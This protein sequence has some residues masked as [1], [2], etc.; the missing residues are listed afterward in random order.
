MSQS[1]KIF[2]E[3]KV[4]SGLDGM[5]GSIGAVPMAA[6][7]TGSPGGLNPS[8]VEVG[9]LATGG[10]LCST[11]ALISSASRV[12]YFNRASGIRYFSYNY[13]LCYSLTYQQVDLV[14]SCAW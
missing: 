11:I 4:P 5:G 8:K 1:S 12:S 2:Y 9:S 13:I 7:P 6:I 3:E 10:F 14:L